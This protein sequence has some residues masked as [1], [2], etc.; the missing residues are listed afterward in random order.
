MMTVA[1]RSAEVEAAYFALCDRS[2]GVEE[3]LTWLTDRLA[4]DRREVRARDYVV[5]GV[6]SASLSTTGVPGEAGYVAIVWRVEG[7][8]IVIYGAEYFTGE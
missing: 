7:K 1:F 6:G 3:A 8:L 5:D 4:A 2:N